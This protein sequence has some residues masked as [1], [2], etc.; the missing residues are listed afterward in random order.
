M[1][2]NAKT[3][4]E[5]E[6]LNMRAF[7]RALLLLAA[8]G[9]LL[10]C[11]K[12]KPAGETPAAD[13]GVEKAEPAKAEPAAAGEAATD[14]EAPDKGAEEAAVD[15]TPIPDVVATVNGVEVKADEYRAE[16]EKI[17]SRGSKIPGERMGRIKENILKRIIEK[18][19]IEQEVKK[20]AVEVTAEEI[21]AAF[22]DYKKRFRTDEQ[23]Q[24]Y[25]KHGKVTVEQIRERMRAKRALEKLIEKVG[26]L[27]VTDEEA[28]DFYAKNERFYVEKEGVRAS[29]ILVKL[30]EKAEEAAVKEAE[31]KIKSVQA[32]LKK[33]MD[34]AEAA[35]KF[36]E[37]PSAPKGGDLGFFGRGQMVKPFEDVA[38]VL[39]IGKLSEPV[40]TR[41]G[42]HII[43]VDE[44][45]EERKK[46]L[47]EVKEQILESLRNK[48]F[49]KERRTL[50]QKL[51]E[52]A[53]V[54]QFI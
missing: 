12:G 3:A 18:E 28:L 4:L 40:R 45:R 47:D 5:G 37:G 25:L 34:F 31:K 41:F 6:G 16:L 29:H 7:H 14:K 38:F 23:F 48:K 54:E 49:F 46:P 52:S 19:L 44:K 30:D 35:K 10:A 8:M 21:D 33:G 39:P 17:T 13:K 50:I 42:F 11:G 27:V 20:Q 32:E 2:T 24:N 22:E 9:L 51:T 15:E 43:K 53:K 26:D 36:S 1:E